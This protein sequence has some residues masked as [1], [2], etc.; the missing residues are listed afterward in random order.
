MKEVTTI[1]QGFNAVARESGV[2]SEAASA[3][4]LQ[5]GQAMGSGV[6]QG[7]ELR[8]ILEQMPQLTQLIAQE[9]GIAAGQVKA[10]GAEGKITS[11]VIF[12]AALQKASQGATDLNSKLT[13][14]QQA[15]NNFNKAIDSAS[16]ALGTTLI[17]ALTTLIEAIT[18]VIEAVGLLSQ[19]LN[20]LGVSKVFEFLMAPARA[21][22]EL[23]NGA[24]ENTE[25]LSGKAA[26]AVNS[27]SGLPA[28]IQSAKDKTE[29]LKEATKQLAVHQRE[30]QAAVGSEQ[31]DIDRKLQVTQAV[32]K[33]PEKQIN[34]AKLQQAN[35]SLL[36][37]QRLSVGAAAQ[38]IYQL[39]ISNAKLEYAAD[40]NGS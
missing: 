27:F 18:P 19:K 16:V 30:Y 26:E 29:Q 17:P 14:T 34:D 3:A 1:Y 39:T 10:F 25:D 21:F 23:V 40:L 11:D 36:Q 32:I 13:P 31:G 22:G 15:M 24:T 35:C 12:F 5:L 6:L 8:S 20:E 4:F 38:R 9:M 33:C 7:D 37:Q 28:P 2:S